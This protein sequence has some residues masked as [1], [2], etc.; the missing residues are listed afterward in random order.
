MGSLV[1]AFVSAA[2]R[3]ILFTAQT[4]LFSYFNKMV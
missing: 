4:N 1:F 3:S 2:S